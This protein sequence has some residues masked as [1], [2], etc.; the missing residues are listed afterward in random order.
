MVIC[1]VYS[2]LIGELI[3]TY[4]AAKCSLICIFIESKRKGRA[5][6]FGKL[7]YVNTISDRLETE[8]V[9]FLG[10]GV[11]IQHEA[12]GSSV[13]FVIGSWAD[14]VILCI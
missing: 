14:E 13:E 6:I 10:G 9:F 12:A 8:L 3:N 11:M 1:L 2:V 7:F 5:S 4:E